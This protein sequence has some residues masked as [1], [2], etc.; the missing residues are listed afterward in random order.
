[1]PVFGRRKK[2]AIDVGGFM[3]SAINAFLED[4]QSGPASSNG[5]SNGHHPDSK[6]GEHRLGTAGAVALGVAAVAAGR[7]VYKR[8]RQFDLAETAAHVEERLKG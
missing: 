3:S 7:A 8:A 5:S 2:S 1:M 4:G 6:Q